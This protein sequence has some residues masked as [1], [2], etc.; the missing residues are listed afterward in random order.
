MLLSELDSTKSWMN[1]HVSDYSGFHYRQFLLTV[2]GNQSD[3]LKEQFAIQYTSL[4][5][6]EYQSIVDQV[7]TFPGH[8]ALWDHRLVNIIQVTEWPPFENSC[9]FSFP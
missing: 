3:S 9:T 2:L 6:K 4:V 8:E 1:K 7:I 5:Q